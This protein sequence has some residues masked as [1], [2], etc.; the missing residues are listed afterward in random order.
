M[1]TTAEKYDKE[2]NFYAK[3]GTSKVLTQENQFSF[4]SQKSPEDM[5][6]SSG[7]SSLDLLTPY[8]RVVDENNEGKITILKDKEIKMNH[9]SGEN[10]GDMFSSASRLDKAS[11][12]VELSKEPLFNNEK[13]D[14]YLDSK[15]AIV[16]PVKKSTFKR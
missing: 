1:L 2:T 12:S 10:S 9:S 7:S 3:E 6:Y 15:L 8:Q 5:I 16:I 14:I 4:E 13:C 11:L